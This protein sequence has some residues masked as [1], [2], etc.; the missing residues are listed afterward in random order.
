MPVDALARNACMASAGI[1]LTPDNIPAK[2]SRPTS[3][4]THYLYSLCYA[5]R[6]AILYHLFKNENV[7]THSEGHF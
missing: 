4:Y 3:L 5:T 1:L 6:Y 2:G 7:G